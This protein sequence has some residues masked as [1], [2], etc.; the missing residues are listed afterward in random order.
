MIV[1]KGGY[2]VVQLKWLMCIDVL[3]KYLCS[4]I[5]YEIL[6]T[7]KWYVGESIIMDSHNVM[8]NKDFYYDWMIHAF[9]DFVLLLH[10]EGSEYLQNDTLD[11]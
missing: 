8:R 10:L 1:Q 2:T 5:P 3:Y 7:R 9:R 6:S 4:F 11:M